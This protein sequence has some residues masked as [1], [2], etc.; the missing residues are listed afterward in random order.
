MSW[1]GMPSVMQT[2]SVM[3]AAA[4]SMIASAAKGA[5]TKI[6]DAFAPVASTASAMALKTGTPR[7]EVPP[8]PGLVP[9]TTFVPNACI[10][11][12]WKPPSRPVM[13]WTMTFVEESKRMLIRPLD[14]K[15]TRL[16]SSHSQISYAV[17]CLKKKNN[18]C[19]H[20]STPD[21][22]HISISHYVSKLLYAVPYFLHIL[23]RHVADNSS[24]HTSCSSHL[25]RLYQ[26]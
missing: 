19:I 12:E 16:N 13:P 5:G 15:S 14:R 17:F 24:Y 9:P 7:C 25:Y 22:I 4:A 26:H 21:Q 8:L 2:I 3:P 6:P 10:C 11:S 20:Y 23:M 1:I 18:S